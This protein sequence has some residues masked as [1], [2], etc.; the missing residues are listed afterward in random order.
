MYY[1]ENDPIGY[2][3]T[4]EY[5]TNYPKTR[6]NSEEHILDADAD[7]KLD[8][9][10]NGNDILVIRNFEARLPRKKWQKAGMASF[11]SLFFRLCFYQVKYTF[12]VDL[13]SDCLN[14]KDLLI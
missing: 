14:L 13:H 4:A 12:S 1:Y 6:R 7:V 8:A 11:C 9:L 10:S 2:K 3:T 5:F